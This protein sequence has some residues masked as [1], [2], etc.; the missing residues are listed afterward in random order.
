M[1]EFEQ[2][3]KQHPDWLIRKGTQNKDGQ[4]DK[5]AGDN[6]DDEQISEA[7]RN[8]IEKMISSNKEIDPLDATKLDLNSP[9][10]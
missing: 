5:D 4:D 2:M 9:E 6:G 1:K 7:K 8:K 10:I 3:Y